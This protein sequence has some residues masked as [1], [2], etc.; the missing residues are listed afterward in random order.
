MLWW[1]VH[2]ENL[3]QMLFVT[4]WK[5]LDDLGGREVYSVENIRSDEIHLIHQVEW[6]YSSFS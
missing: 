5:I 3:S 4:L 2:S 1:C 6:V